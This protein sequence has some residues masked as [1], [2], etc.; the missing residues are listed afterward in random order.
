[1]CQLFICIV[2]NQPVKIKTPIPSHD[3]QAVWD[4]ILAE[5]KLQLEESE[6][7]RWFSSI[8]PIKIENTSLTI[9]VPNQF[10]YERLE[11]NYL[12][13]LRKGIKK[14]LGPTGKLEYKLVMQGIKQNNAAST[15]KNNSQNLEKIPVS[16]YNPFVIPGIRDYKIDS[17][18]NENYTFDN[19]IEGD[20]NRVARQAGINITKNPGKLFNPLIAYGDTGLGK[21]HLA[22]AIGNGLLKNFPDFKVV[23]IST[24]KFTNQF[25]LAVKNNAAN[26]FAQY[27]N[28][29]DALLIDDIHFFAGKTGTQEVFFHLFNHLQQQG[30]QIVM[31][32]DKSPKDLHEIEDRLISRFKWGLTIELGS[33]DYETRMAILLSKMEKLNI[34]LPESVRDYLCQNVKTNIREIEG[35][36]ISLIAQSSL[37]K[38]AIDIPLV[39]EILQEYCTQIIQGISMEDIIKIICEIQ[40]INPE[41]LMSR[42]RKGKI[43]Q[44]RHLAMYFCRKFVANVSLKAIGDYFGGKDHSTVIHACKSVENMLVTDPLL[45]S[46]AQEIEKKIVKSLR[47]K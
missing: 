17:N 29:V 7:T 43:V 25:I 15:I 33:P 28:N 35:V 42:S 45:K 39:E 8:K 22:H 32:S 24:D 27:F 5:V 12:D 18:L 37:N 11:S 13:F 34:Q 6:F 23:Y 19:F 31:T 40:K 44:S 41:L 47:V 36:L 9:E 38:R 4:S 20:C 26:E 46:I 10:V 30:K 1:M 3:P 16:A 14:A 21:T 2:V